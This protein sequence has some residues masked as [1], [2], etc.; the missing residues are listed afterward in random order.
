[1]NINELQKTFIIAEIGINH[2]GSLDKLKK[3]IDVAKECGADAVKLQV[4]T[5]YDLVAGNVPFTFGKGDNKHT[6]DLAE[7]FYNRRIKEEW[8]SIIYN[9]CKKIGIICF[10]TPFSEGTVDLLEE[11]GNPI[12]K[13]SSGDITHLP[14]IDYIAKKGKPIIMSTGKSTLAD[15]DE[16][17]RTIKKNNHD[18]FALLHCISSYP[19]PYDKLN[20]RV[21]NTLKETF[22]S[23][24][25]FSDHSEGYIS[26][27]AAVCMGAK[28]VEKH[29]TLD[30][31][32]YGPDHW[33]SLDPTELKA[34]VDNIRLVEK[35]FGS[36]KKEVVD[37]ESIVYKRASRSIVAADDIKEGEVFS[38]KNLTYKRPGTGIRPKYIDIICGRKAL[39]SFKADETITW[40]DI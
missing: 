4:M 33:F 38:K 12:Y 19:T 40:E 10:A 3:M 20:L 24:V 36:P 11:V 31:D 8:L 5:G 14:L 9:Y 1:M 35:T 17:V 13:I 16:A 39:K 29:F 23:I 34:L 15:V 37:V 27:V 7:L 6:E 26:S 18:N 30:K 25:G 2:D 28:I 21:I 32:D 22:Q